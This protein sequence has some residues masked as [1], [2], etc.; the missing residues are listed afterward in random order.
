MPSSRVDSTRI[1]HGYYSLQEIEDEAGAFTE[2]LMRPVDPTARGL[3]LPQGY[4]PLTT[5][6]YGWPCGC[7]AL[8]AATLSS[9]KSCLWRACQAHDSYRPGP[10]FARLIGA[11]EQDVAVPRRDATYRPGEILVTQV[12]EPRE[13]L[14]GQ[15]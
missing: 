14:S 9:I 5:V 4:K 11:R 10:T 13:Q 8:G 6:G 1:Y 2:V 3:E 15:S 7:E 12:D